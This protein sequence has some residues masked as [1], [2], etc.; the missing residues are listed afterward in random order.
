MVTRR[1][2][3]YTMLEIV[4]VIAIFGIFL[5]ILVVVT[6]EMR[7]YEKRMPVNFMANPQVIAVLSRLRRDVLDASA[8][9]TY[10]GSQDSYVQSEKTLIIRTMVGPA[11]RIVVWDFSKPG[12]VK[13]IAWNVAIPTEW[14]ARGLP[15]DFS[16]TFDAITVEGHP[17]GVRVKAFDKKGMLSVDAYMQPRTHWSVPPPAPAP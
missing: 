15:E 9:D 4:M 14:V 2:R 16:A 7:G 12:E 13:R 3:G 8:S 17:F 6:A 11:E 5:L 1:Q 10:P